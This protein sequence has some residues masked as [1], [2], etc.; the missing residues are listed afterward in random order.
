MT[1]TAIV[2]A[3]SARSPSVRCPTF[4]PFFGRGFFDAFNDVTALWIMPL[5]GIVLS[6]FVGWR[7]PRDLVIGELNNDHTLRL[8]RWLF[9]GFFFLIRWVAPVAI[10]LIFL[11]QL[12]F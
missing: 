7:L 10:A 8:P 2:L 1:L 11:S 12:Q 9:V 3:P 4:R 6:I 5:S